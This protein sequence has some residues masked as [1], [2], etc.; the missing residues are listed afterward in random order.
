MIIEN[1]D[2]DAKI[3]CDR[4]I[5]DACMF[6]IDDEEIVT[7]L[8]AFHLTSLGFTNVHCFND[9]LEAID[10]LRHIRAEIVLTD[11][12]MPGLGGCYL[13]QLAKKMEHL[14]DVPVIGITADRSESTRERLLTSGAIEVLHKPIDSQDLFRVAC[15][16][17]TRK[18]TSR[19]PNTF[20][21][22]G[23]SIR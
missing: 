8:L 12:N 16:A 15:E 21:R 11:V 5:Y 6:V 13:T 9:S 18:T 19:R 14:R 7:E 10:T 4:R 20:I 1:T 17:L 22:N 23:V 3:P 2:S